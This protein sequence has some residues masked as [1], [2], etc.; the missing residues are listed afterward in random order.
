MISIQDVYGKTQ[1][2]LGQGT[3]PAWSPFAT[4]KTFVG[5]GGAMFTSPI[6]GFI[7]PQIQT[8][9]ASLLTFTATTPSTATVTAV[10]PAGGS[11]P[12]VYDVHADDI[13]SLKYTNSYYVP[14]TTVTPGV[15]DA[16][17][18]VDSSA[19]AIQSIAPFVLTRGSSVKSVRTA[20]GLQFTA[21]FTGVWDSHGK[22]LAPNGASA[23]LVDGKHGK[24]LSVT[25]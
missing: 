18:T 21:H 22:N 13:T 7:F 11:G 15:S 8:G 17:V 4:T 16:V 5:S 1:Q 2:I 20:S 24:V 3:K 25:P 14:A 6:A 10:Q 9:L 12:F 23:I 19:G